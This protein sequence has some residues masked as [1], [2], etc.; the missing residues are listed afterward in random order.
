MKRITL[1]TI[2]VCLAVCASALAL[3]IYANASLNAQANKVMEK[4][5]PADLME[6]K[7]TEGN[8]ASQTRDGRPAPIRNTVLLTDTQLAYFKDKAT[9]AFRETLGLDIPKELKFEYSTTVFGEVVY[10]D[11]TWDDGMGYADGNDLQKIT[12]HRDDVKYIAGFVTN[13]ISKPAALLHIVTNNGYDIKKL[14]GIQK[15]GVEALKSDMGIVV[16]EDYYVSSNIRVEFACCMNSIITEYERYRTSTDLQWGKTI[17]VDWT[18][19]NF[20]YSYS[21]SFEEINLVKN[22]GKIVGLG[23]L[24]GQFNPDGSIPEFAQ[25]TSEQQKSMQARA[26]TFLLKKGIEYGK[27]ANSY[28]AVDTMSFYF[29]SMT[30][31]DPNHAAVFIVVNSKLEIMEYRY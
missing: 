23:N 14:Q 21:A 1:P 15:L 5:A 9:L 19:A 25:F 22:T 17:V 3:P 31:N 20:L 11:L 24:E 6:E 16:P 26:E 10:V 28:Q 13:D 2:L 29:E 27:M 7:N 4:E 12:T 30:P 8:Q 18:K